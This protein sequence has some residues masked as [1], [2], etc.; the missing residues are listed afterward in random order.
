MP[1]I[2]DSGRNVLCRVAAL[3]ARTL[4]DLRQRERVPLTR[5]PG[6]V[7]L[8]SLTDSAALPA[9]EVTVAAI[10]VS[11]VRVTVGWKVPKLPGCVGML[12][13]SVA[14]TSPPTV[15]SASPVLRA[16]SSTRSTAS[17]EFEVNWRRATEV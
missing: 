7:V 5:W 13:F 8:P 15:V 17:S 9:V 4:S 2:S 16:A 1:V 3:L 10:A 11:Y 6:D 14:G 12:R